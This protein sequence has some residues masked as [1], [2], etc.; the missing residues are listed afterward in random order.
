MKYLAGLAALAMLAAPA[1]F[2]EDLVPATTGDIKSFD[3]QIKDAK[4]GTRVA[5]IGR[6]A[7]KDT[8]K[9]KDK[10]KDKDKDRLKDKDRDK[11]AK[12]P[13]RAEDKDRAKD[14]G[15]EK[16]RPDG[17][18]VKKEKD[19]FGKTVSSE[20]KKMRGGDSDARPGMGRFV[21]EQRRE[22]EQKRPDIKPGGD[23]HG[24][25]IGG[26]KDARTSAPGGASG[27]RP[28]QGHGQAPPPD[29][30]H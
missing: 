21:S 9:G 16:E 2:A 8:D 17:L 11:K 10:D 4:K 7:D 23:D 13:D 18:K 26:E 3:G 24:G 14:E 12:N 6:D 22:N 30:R 15:K 20:A 28:D 1:A 25:R 29:H 27:G 19:N 5:E